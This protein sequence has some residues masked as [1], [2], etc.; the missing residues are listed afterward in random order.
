MFPVSC[1][2][3]TLMIGDVPR[4]VDR[5][6]RTIVGRSYPNTQD[7][8]L[9]QYSTGHPFRSWVLGYIVYQI[10]LMKMKEKY[11]YLLQEY[12][13]VLFMLNMHFIFYL[14]TWRHSVP[15]LVQKMNHK[16]YIKVLNSSQAMNRKN[17]IGIQIW[18]W[19]TLRVFPISCG[20]IFADHN[21][22]W[23]KAT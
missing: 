15:M 1:P 5:D 20:L 18:I 21:K 11:V 14:P 23:V 22:K 9:T 3:P 4:C 13:I 2:V 6:A 12:D 10:W 8:T 7:G 17:I 16:R 19:I